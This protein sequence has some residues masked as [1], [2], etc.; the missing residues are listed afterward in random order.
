M[1]CNT[2]QVTHLQLCF[3]MV[4]TFSRRCFFYIIRMFLSF[5]VVFPFFQIAEHPKFVP[6]APST[7][8]SDRPAPT[9]PAGTP[10]LLGG[11]L[12]P[13]EALQTP[14]GKLQHT[15]ALRMPLGRMHLVAGLCVLK[16]LLHM[17]YILP[18]TEKCC[19]PFTQRNT[20]CLQSYDIW[21]KL[22]YDVICSLQFET[23][24]P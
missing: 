23:C 6:F 8:F 10:S 9:P 24:Y 3:F 13:A 2:I 12:F 5:F 15:T 19:L 22:S 16:S 21:Q 18:C 20:K 11:A 7:D 17:V 4:F 14:Q 1:A